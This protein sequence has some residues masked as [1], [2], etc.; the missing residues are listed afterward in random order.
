MPELGR[1]T[2]CTIVLVAALAVAVAHAGAGAAARVRQADLALVVVLDVSGSMEEAVDGGVKRD[3][4]R[5]GLERT[6]ASLPNTAV[7]ALR[8]LGEGPEV[9]TDECAASRSAI[10]LLPYDPAA[11]GDVLDDVRWDGATPLTHS[12]REAFA[13]LAGVN[14]ARREVLLI[15]DGED[16]CRTDPVA[17]A[18]AGA[19]D[20]RVHTI[21]LGR[22]VSHQLAGIA[23]VTGGRYANAYDELSFAEAAGASL[24]DL[25]SGGEGQD[26][27]TGPLTLEVILDVSNSMWGRV[28]GRVKMDLAREA[29]AGALADL[30]GDVHVALRAYGHRVAHDG[31]REL[32]CSDTE[33]LLAPGPHAVDDVVRIAADLVPR[34]RTPIA[35]SLRAASRDV[36]AMSGPAALLLV[37]DGIESCDGDPVAVAA[38]LKASG[39]PV[40]L[41][42]V[43]LGVDADAARS[44]AD[45]ASAGGGGYFDAPTA[46]DLTSGL[47]QAVSSSR[48]LVVS[49]RDLG[50]FP[51]PVARV[52]GGRDAAEPQ[53]IDAGDYS[54]EEHLGEGSS[55]FFAVAGAPGEAV[56][57]AGLVCTLGIVQVRSGDWVAGA[58]PQLVFF[59]GVDARGERI[60]GSRMRVTGNMGDWVRMSVPVGDDGLA[61][62]RVYRDFGEVHRDVLFRVT[63]E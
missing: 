36:A 50:R 51:S 63:A 30:G 62:F 32:G 52:T 55:R 44:L 20:I 27:A 41:H 43:G 48:E 58:A 45:V 59:Q 26:T 29:L 6:L 13:D 28:D 56:E 1:P 7:V 39:T 49:G 15:S 37:S 5:R 54:F 21:S 24:P 31:D 33:L 9:D 11:W 18:R 42:T 2:R 40:V 8:L 47:R 34:G 60:R 57:V 19:A 23:L 53:V 3:L 61:R 16:T 12:L 4:A 46:A 38:E 10:G 17:T 14:A 22:G 25:A 35:H